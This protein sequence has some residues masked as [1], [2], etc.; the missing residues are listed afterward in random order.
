[1]TAIPELPGSLVPHRS[2]Q[3][4]WLKRHV[5]R[6]CNLEHER[7]AVVFGEVLPDV[8]EPAYPRFPGSQPVSFGSSD[9]N[10][11]EQFE[12]VLSILSHLQL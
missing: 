1:M 7:C 4:I 11:L 5:A 12:C 10:K 6:L 9:L 8:L 2:E 3:E